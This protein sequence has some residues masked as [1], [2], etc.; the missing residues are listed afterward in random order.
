MTQPSKTEIIRKLFDAYRT[1]TRAVVEDLLA[2]D[3]TFTS[4]YDDRI[5]KGVYFDRCWPASLAYIHSNELKQICEAG[6]TAFVLYKCVTVDGR[7]FRNTEHFAFASGKVKAINATLAPLTKTASFLPSN[8]TPDQASVDAGARRAMV[9]SPP[10]TRHARRPF[11]R[12]PAP[13]A[14]LRPGGPR[15]RHGGS[16]RG[17]LDRAFRQAEL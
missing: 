9:A 17:R 5:S 16:G 12:P 10:E 13:A 2:D 3:F 1:K 4:P 6:D 15:R 7:E 11:P 8:P 14:R